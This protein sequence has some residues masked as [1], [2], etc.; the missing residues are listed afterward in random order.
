MGIKAGKIQPVPSV[1]KHIWGIAQLGERLN[2]IQEVSGG[3]PLISTNSREYAKALKTLC[4]QGFLLFSFPWYCPSKTCFRRA[5]AHRKAHN[6]R[7]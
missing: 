2:G 5:K 3:I 4:F 1:N 6:R 7:K